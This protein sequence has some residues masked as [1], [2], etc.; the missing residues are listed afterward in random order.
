MK[1]ARVFAM[2]IP[3]SWISNVL[4]SRATCIMMINQFEI[5]IKNTLHFSC[6][7]FSKCRWCLPFAIPCFEPTMQFNIT[8]LHDSD[9]MYI[10][11][12]VVTLE[13][14]SVSGLL[15]YRRQ[16]AVWGTLHPNNRDSFFSV[17]PFRLYRLFSWCPSFFY[18]NLLLASM[19]C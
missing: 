6:F 15:D 12:S 1:T 7:I 17:A 16:W 5:T 3:I 2:V 11:Q 19:L 13:H 14:F 4:L 10:Q 8:I 18:S 9:N